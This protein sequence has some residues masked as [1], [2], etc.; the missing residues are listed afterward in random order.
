MNS[1]ESNAPR[2]ALCVTQNVALRRT[3]RRAL[4]AA[5]TSIEFRD[6]LAELP[7]DA[8]ITIVDRDCR[9]GEGDPLHAAAEQEGQIIVVGQSLQE[10]DVL[11]LLRGRSLNHIIGNPADHDAHELLV[12]SAKILSGDIFG[13]DKYLAWGGSMSERLVGGYQDKRS[14]LRDIAE[15]ARNIGARRQ[16][17]SKIESVTDELLMNALYDAPALRYGSRRT[18]ARGDDDAVPSLPQERARLC[19]AND[20]RYFGVSVQD[21]YGELHK[22]TIIDHLLRARAERGQPRTTK[23]PTG[24]AGLGLYFIFA[25]TTRFIANIEPGVRTEVICLF[26]LRQ[27][28]TRSHSG[29]RSFHFFHV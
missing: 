27:D 9:I 3:L 12:T 18:G 28:E 24:G 13:L 11:T 10:D 7:A 2:R 8:D 4:S 19:F 26:D 25:A 17:V 14:A 1:A 22:D 23:S 16:L 6:A 15:Y 5:G 21:N 20:E 29:A